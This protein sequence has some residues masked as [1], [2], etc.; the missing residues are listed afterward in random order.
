V[1]L[2]VDVM[3]HALARVPAIAWLLVAQSFAAEQYRVYESL[4]VGMAL[5]QVL[6]L[7]CALDLCWFEIY[8]PS[9]FSAT[10]GKCGWLRLVRGAALESAAL[11]HS[12]ST[13]STNGTRASDH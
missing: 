8:V 13:T 5:Y 4:S 7:L 11:N 10:H 3:F 1:V 6:V 9:S 2:G 12:S